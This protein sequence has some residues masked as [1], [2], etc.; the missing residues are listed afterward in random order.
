MIFRED[1][2]KICNFRTTNPVELHVI[3]VIMLYVIGA[4]EKQ[5]LFFTLKTAP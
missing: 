1:V 5:I 4:S 3:A 2:L